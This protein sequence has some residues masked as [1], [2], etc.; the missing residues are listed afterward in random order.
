MEFN[1]KQFSLNHTK[2]SMKIGTDA[3]LLSALTNIQNPNNIL[4]IGT[5]CGIIALCMAQKYKYSKITAI[6]IDQ[7]S[8]E[9]AKDNFKKSKYSSQLIAKEIDINTYAKT[10]EEKYDLIITNPPFFISSLESYNEKRNKARHTKSLNFNDLIQ[11]TE[12][13]LSQDG[14]LSLILPTKES[15]IFELMAKENYFQTIY[16]ANIYS[17]IDKKCERVVLH[18]Q[19]TQEN[20]SITNKHIIIT[21]EETIILRNPDNSLTQTYKNLVND[22][23]I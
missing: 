5:G 9:E 15:Q 6:D 20:N 13:L 1:C 8:I 17:K 12:K 4:D 14:I 21:S 23:L 22:Y 19:R 18:L 7:N 16:K 11:S 2:S 10:Q 3:I